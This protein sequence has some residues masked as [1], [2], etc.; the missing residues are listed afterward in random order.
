MRL[1]NLS[2]TR[3][4]PRFDCTDG[5]TVL[6][7]TVEWGDVPPAWDCPAVDN[8]DSDVEIVFEESVIATG[9]CPGEQT[10]LRSWSATD[11]CGNS[12]SEIQL[13]YIEDTTP[14]TFVNPPADEVLFCDPEIPP[15]NSPD[16]VDLCDPNV[17]VTFAQDFEFNVNFG[18]GVVGDK[19]TRIWTAL[20]NC[21]NSSEHVQMIALIPDCPS[22]GCIDIVNFHDKPEAV[23]VNVDIFPTKVR[24]DWEVPEGAVKAQARIISTLGTTYHM[25]H[26]LNF[27]KKV[28]KGFFT[29]GIEY[30][31]Q[32]RYYSQ[33]NPCKI[34]SKME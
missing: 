28:N 4:I 15:V 16:A 25:I 31:V 24:F 17:T 29:P 12:S 27:P 13:I 10:L 3:T 30:T 23:D 20:D 21:G 9:D 33:F 5:C 32:I 14:P 22:N 26:N 8:C 2:M 11:N 7:L 6:D 18:N 19:L 34:G 1:L